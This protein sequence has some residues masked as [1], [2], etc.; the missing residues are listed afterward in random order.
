VR[1][2]AKG[3][4]G[5]TLRS[6]R[7]GTRREHHAEAAQDITPEGRARACVH[8]GSARWR[9]CESLAV[10][11]QARGSGALLPRQAWNTRTAAA[12]PNTHCA[13]PLAPV[14]LPIRSLVVVCLCLSAYSD[15][16]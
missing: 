14:T 9:V 6:T 12:Q 7:S 8:G 15:I 4:T 11:R 5:R 13:A 16:K 1:I 3:N 10:Q 2:T